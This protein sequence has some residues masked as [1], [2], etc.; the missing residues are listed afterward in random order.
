MK[1]WLKKEHA[2]AFRAF[3]LVAQ[4]LP[5]KYSHILRL[6][7]RFM[8]DVNSADVLGNSYVVLIL[9]NLQVAKWLSYFLKIV[10]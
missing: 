8:A 5:F 1:T 3:S 10:L 2:F 6:L 7:G 4:I 9:V